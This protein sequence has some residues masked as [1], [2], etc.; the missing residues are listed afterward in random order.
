MKVVAWIQVETSE[1]LFALCFT[2][3]GLA[4]VCFPGEPA[5]K[6]KADWRPPE[7]WA[8]AAARELRAFLAGESVVS[9]LPL[10]APRREGF[11]SRVWE[12][13]RTI[14]RGR[15][16]TYGQVAAELGSPRSARAVGA[17]CRA[18]PLPLWI[19]CHRVVAADGGLGG[20][21]PGLAWKRLLLARE[22]VFFP[23]NKEGRSVCL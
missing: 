1:G 15:T 12:A 6:A 5:P 13:L 7:A 14:P 8:T 2:P 16:K 21:R 10:D 11:E 17:A 19:P 20:Y 4:A 9:T 18:N 22:G 23:E 3:K